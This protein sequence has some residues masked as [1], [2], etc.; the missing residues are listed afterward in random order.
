M[1]RNYAI[2]KIKFFCSIAI[3]CIH[4]SPFN[5]Y[6][7]GR[8]INVICRIGVPL[9]FI[10]S[11]YLFYNKFSFNYTKK[12]FIK[13]TKLFISWV[14]FYII[15][16]LS[17]I[18]ISNVMNGKFI[19]Y[20][21]KQYFYEFN[22]M[23][24]YY[25]KGIIRYHLWY[26]S[27][28]II[29]IPILY[30]ILKSKWVN[31]AVVITLILNIIGIFIYNTDISPIETTRD[32]LFLGLF[33]SVLGT[34][35]G[36]NSEVIKN[37]FNSKI[38]YKYILAILLF[39]GTSIIERVIYDNH[40][41]KTSDF[42]ISTIPL[43]LLIFGICIIKPSKN[44]SIIS[45]IGSNSIGIYLI[46]IGIIDILDILIF[47]MNMVS[48]YTNVYWQIIYTPIIILLSYISYSTLQKVKYIIRNKLKS[49]VVR[50]EVLT[51]S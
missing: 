40:F 13:I 9:F 42:Y 43:S 22:I 28:M 37:K 33:Y 16:G 47:K 1:E 8:I 38:S 20:N 12:Y 15:L 44:K 31:K 26:L 5:G 35:I 3:V 51:N 14:I 30:C 36:K 49:Y 27:S 29:M 24:L 7:I 6:E 45:N 17:C 34:Y 21:Y 39:T 2:D 10:S 4:T 25:A 18:S 11:G 32:A 50:K 46:H 48:I 41:T 23:D 19:F